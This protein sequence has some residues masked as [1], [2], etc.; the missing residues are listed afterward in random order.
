MSTT[1]ELKKSKLVRISLKDYETLR[2]LAYKAHKPMTEILEEII[3]LHE[4]KRLTV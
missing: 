3:K 2:K 4:S 1:K